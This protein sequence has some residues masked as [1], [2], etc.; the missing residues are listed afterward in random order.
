MRKFSTRSSPAR[1]RWDHETDGQPA[2]ASN[3]VECSALNVR[4]DCKQREDSLNRRSGSA[5]LQR[6]LRDHRRRERPWAAMLGSDV[7]EQISRVAE[8]RDGSV[9]P[10]LATWQA[11]WSIEG[12]H[13]NRNRTIRVLRL[14]DVVIY[15][16][17]A[18][19]PAGRFKR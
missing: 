4:A 11:A 1:C 16:G 2:L 19:S 17:R 13:S 14:R 12:H 18:E 15:E 9:R 5:L 6:D 8:V 10:S 7:R 3:A